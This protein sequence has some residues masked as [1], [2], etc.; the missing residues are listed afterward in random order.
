MTITVTVEELDK[1][2]SKHSTWFY[3]LLNDVVPKMISKDNFMEQFDRDYRDRCARLIKEYIKEH[4]EPN[5][6][7]DL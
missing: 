3:A 7:N 5:W 1:F 2:M 4:P 6:K